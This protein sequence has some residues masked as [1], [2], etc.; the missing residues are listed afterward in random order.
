MAVRFLAPTSAC[1]VTSS[2]CIGDA[3]DKYV[4]IGLVA[5]V[6]GAACAAFYRSG[7]ATATQHLWT[8]AA[9]QG[10]STE[11]VGPFNVGGSGVYVD[12]AGTRAS[13]LV[14]MD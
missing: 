5:P 6:D 3:I 1:S 13:A 7:S 9:S 2:A 12:L 14:A 10:T 8:L 4:W 11:M